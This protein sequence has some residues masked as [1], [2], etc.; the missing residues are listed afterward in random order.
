[1]LTIMLRLKG[2]V[3]E[4]LVCIFKYA[5]LETIYYLTNNIRSFYLSLISYFL[6]II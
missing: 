5:V 3:I 4:M 1:M 6:L 2:H